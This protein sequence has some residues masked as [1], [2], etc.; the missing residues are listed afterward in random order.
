VRKK[1]RDDS[2]FEEIRM[3]KGSS[4]FWKNLPEIRERFVE[5]VRQRRDFMQ[6]SGC[7]RL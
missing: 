7:H 3:M 4:D 2:L 1:Q 6:V 5:D